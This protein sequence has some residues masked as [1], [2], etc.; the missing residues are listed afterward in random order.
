MR[1][2][3]YWTPN[4]L[5]DLSQQAAQWFQLDQS[6]IPTLSDE[7]FR[8]LLSAPNHYGFHA[9]IKPPFRLDNGYTLEDVE[10]A[11]TRFTT[12]PAN[13]SFDL[14]LFK[15]ARIGN[16][17][18]LKLQDNSPT[19]QSFAQSVVRQFDHFR[20]PAEE[21]EI[22]RRRSAGLTERQ[23]ELLLQWG[24]PYVFDE[25]R[26]HLTLTGKV[27]DPSH[28]TSLETEI[29]TRFAPTLKSPF[30]IDSLTLFLQHDNQPFFK[31][32]RWKL[33]TV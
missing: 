26:F 15:V 22:E 16:F 21:H 30:A 8:Q 5:T 24:Y 27:S 23:D 29:N 28:F 11:V 1:I 7:A 2:A 10:E 32:K 25:F 19:L 31:Y 4:L 13:H 20:K 6:P 33:P 18:C 14:P 3:L 9:T 17:F 12:D